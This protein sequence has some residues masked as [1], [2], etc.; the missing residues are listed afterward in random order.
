MRLSIIFEHGMKFLQI[1]SLQVNKLVIDI[2]QDGV[3][4]Q[5]LAW[6]YLARHILGLES[7]PTHP[8][9]GPRATNWDGNVPT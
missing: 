1:I 7:H 9:L 5:Y 3:T 4:V 2:I 6:V 8:Y